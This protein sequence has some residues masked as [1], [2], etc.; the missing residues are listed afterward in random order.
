[1]FVH[2]GQLTPPLRASGSHG[3]S[4]L[5]S[6][7]SVHPEN[8]VTQPACNE[9]LKICGVFLETALFQSHHSFIKI[10]RDTC[11]PGNAACEV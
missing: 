2:T 4:H 1:M 5:T 10:P 8:A 3:V 6:G 9:I 11:K 7:V